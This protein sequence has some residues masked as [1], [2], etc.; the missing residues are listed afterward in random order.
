MSNSIEMSDVSTSDEEKKSVKSLPA[1]HTS[2]KSYDKLHGI[3]V[4]HPSRR[5]LNF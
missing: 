5:N 2:Y 1:P 3:E 4:P